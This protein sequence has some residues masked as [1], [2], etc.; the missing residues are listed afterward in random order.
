MRKKSVIGELPKGKKGR[1][2]SISKKPPKKSRSEKATGEKPL[3]EYDYT[4]LIERKKM[5]EQE[6]NALQYTDNTGKIRFV[7]S[8]KSDSKRG[9]PSEKISQY[10]KLTQGIS[11]VSKELSRREDELNYIN[12]KSISNKVIEYLSNGYS[13]TELHKFLCERAKSN[14]N[15]SLIERFVDE[16]REVIASESKRKMHELSDLPLTL[17]RRR[18]LELNELYNTFKDELRRS[19]TVTVGKHLVDLLAQVRTEVEGIKINM[20][21]DVEHTLRLEIEN[22]EIKRLTPMQMVLSAVCAKQNKSPEYY[23]SKLRQSYYYSWNGM[24]N[25]NIRNDASKEVVYPSDE[26][27]DLNKIERLHNEMEEGNTEENVLTVVNEPTITPE[28]ISF[29]EAMKNAY[30]TR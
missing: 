30:K 1:K 29:I 26:L 28:Q 18:I 7:T 13:T 2:P 21:V 16:N 17:K 11:N 23:M 15:I 25:P 3:S 20:N 12:I 9:I 14:I 6:K 24:M 22:E 8:I 10:V 27:Y 4:E 19:P 5:L